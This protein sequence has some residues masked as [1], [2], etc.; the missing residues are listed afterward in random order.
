MDSALKVFGAMKARRANHNQAKALIVVEWRCALTVARA[1][2]VYVSPN[3]PP[4]LPPDNSGNMDAGQTVQQTSC[5]IF[6]STR[7]VVYLSPAVLGSKRALPVCSPSLG[8]H[9]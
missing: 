6:V 9:A 8:L 5:D 4:Q 7:L 1:V 3:C 2:Y